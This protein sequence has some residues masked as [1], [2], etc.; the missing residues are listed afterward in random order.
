M[1]EIVVY[2]DAYHSHDLTLGGTFNAPIGTVG[3]NS[4]AGKDS[5]ERTV[6]F[7]LKHLM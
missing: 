7:F 6:A 4:K 3:S 2:P 1:P 5:R